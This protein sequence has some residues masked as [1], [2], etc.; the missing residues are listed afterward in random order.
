MFIVK[1]KTPKK[2]NFGFFIYYNASLIKN[3]KQKGI[4]LLLN[5]I[6]TIVP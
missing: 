3:Y 5:K 2:Y 6:E 4:I 1:I